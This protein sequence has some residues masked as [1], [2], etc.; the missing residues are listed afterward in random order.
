MAT[1]LE[2]KINSCLV[3]NRLPCRIAFDIAEE[4]KVSR[5]QVGET[6][7]SLKIKISDCQLGFFMKLKATHDDLVGKEVETRLADEIAS[8]LVEGRLACPVAFKISGKFNVTPKEVGD[9]AT[10]QGISVNNCQLGLFPHMN[11]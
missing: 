3:D 9:A 5:R 4:L 7:N 10:M 6:V 1:E 11:K 8:S 2:E